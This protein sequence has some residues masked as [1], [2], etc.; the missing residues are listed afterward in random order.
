MSGFSLTGLTG[1]G[2]IPPVMAGLGGLLLLSGA[3]ALRAF[4]FL[5]VKSRRKEAH[6]STT[7]KLKRQD[8]RLTV[9]RQSVKASF[10]TIWAVG[11]SIASGLALSG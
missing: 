10:S 1:G 9:W 8:A 7:V 6:M 11:T 4:E 2:S 3:T 5:L